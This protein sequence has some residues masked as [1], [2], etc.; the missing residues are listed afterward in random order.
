M[1]TPVIYVQFKSTVDTVINVKIQDLKIALE[2]RNLLILSKLA[3]MDAD[4]QPPKST[5]APKVIK[6]QVKEKPVNSGKTVINVEM[7][8]FLGSLSDKTGKNY[9]V[10]EGQF[11]V[12]LKMEASKNED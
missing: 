8:E 1:N 6:K 10:M 11:I 9:V 3:V 4:I 12:K 2:L 5:L 7:N